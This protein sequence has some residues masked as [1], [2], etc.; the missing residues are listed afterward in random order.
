MSAQKKLETLTDSWYGFD[1]VSGLFS[2]LIGGFGIL[3]LSWSLG[4]TVVSLLTTFV[5]GRR[6]QKRGK[7]TRMFVLAAS[8][9]LGVVGVISLVIRATSFLDSWSVDGLLRIA[10]TLMTTLMM[11]RSFRTLTDTQVKSFFKA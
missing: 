5:I 4:W 6:L 10:L 3:S 9:L 2:V 1:L 8:A 7:I 11:V